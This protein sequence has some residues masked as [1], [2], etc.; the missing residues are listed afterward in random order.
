MLIEHRRRRLDEHRRRK[1]E[2]MEAAGD[3][4]PS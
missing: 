2:R 4:R 3:G 1:R